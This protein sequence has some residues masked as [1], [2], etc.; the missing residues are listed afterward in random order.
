MC[1]VWPRA[2]APVT[3]PVQPDGVAT[4]TDDWSEVSVLCLGHDD[5]WVPS[6]KQTRV[7]HSLVQFVIDLKGLENWTKCI[8]LVHFLHI[9]AATVTVYV[10]ATG[11]AHNVHETTTFLPIVTICQI[12]TDFNFFIDKSQQ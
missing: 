5:W 11:Q 6:R 12:F 2:A 8:C 10:V 3:A 9:L 1:G 4:V 7:T